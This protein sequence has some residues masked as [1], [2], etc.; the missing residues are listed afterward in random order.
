MCD[1]HLCRVSLAAVGLWLAM[2]GSSLGAEDVDDDGDRG[3]RH[4]Q[5]ALSL[6]GF[7]GGSFR[8]S[9]NQFV[10]GVGAGYAVLTGVMPGVRG[11]VLMGDGVGGELVGTLTLTPPLRL[12]LTPFI[13]GEAGRRFEPDFS[14]WL[15]GAG[16]GFFLGDPAKSFSLQA[17]WMIRRFVVADETLDVSG[18]ILSIS[19]RL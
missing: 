3:Y 4:P 18:P 6:Q 16:L 19:L 11:L 9:G 14:G 15:Y 8:E 7:L 5:G 12:Y 17:G 13:M 10:V 1:S 2:S